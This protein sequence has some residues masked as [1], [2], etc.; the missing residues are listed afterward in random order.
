MLAKKT[1]S[2]VARVAVLITQPLTT[3]FGQ[4]DLRESQLQM[5]GHQQMS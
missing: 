2:K 5:Q 4:L 1:W 3:F